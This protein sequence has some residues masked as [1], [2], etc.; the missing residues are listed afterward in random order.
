MGQESLT[1]VDQLTS[2]HIGR[3]IRVQGMNGGYIEGTLAM[4]KHTVMSPYDEEIKSQVAF[5]EFADPIDDGTRYLMFQTS[6]NREA[7]EVREFD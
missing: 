7:T 5:E 6:G 4:I 1:Q 3:V 2:A